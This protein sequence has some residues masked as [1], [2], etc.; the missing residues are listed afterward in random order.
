MLRLGQ[1]PVC[2]VSHLACYVLTCA[3]QGKPYVMFG[4]GN[5][6]SCKPISESDLA[7]FIADCVAQKDKVNQVLPIGGPGER[8]G[9]GA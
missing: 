8:A 3:P 1:R 4:N 7:S 9:L 2:V 5:I 6:A